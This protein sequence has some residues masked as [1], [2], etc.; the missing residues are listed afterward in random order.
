[1]SRFKVE[2]VGFWVHGFRG[3]RFRVKDL[4]V[5][6]QGSG[7][8]VQDSPCAEDAEKVRERLCRGGCG[9]GGDSRGA[10]HARVGR[11]QAPV[12]AQLA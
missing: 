7:S 11:H 8:M 3:S 12:A 6:R 10:G 5:R 1:M 2:E 4:G 9:G